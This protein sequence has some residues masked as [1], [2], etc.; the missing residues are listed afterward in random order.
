MLIG[1][2]LNNH[3]FKIGNTWT[4]CLKKQSSHARLY[5][6]ICIYAH[7]QSKVASSHSSLV[8]RFSKILLLYILSEMVG[9]VSSL[10][11]LVIP[12]YLGFWQIFHLLREYSEASVFLNWELTEKEMQET[13]EI[14]VTR[15]KG[16]WG[17]KGMKGKGKSAM[18]FVE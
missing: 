9:A 5:I 15:N 12:L 10:L 4:Q 16:H 7:T 18:I 1:I 14:L 17:K 6:H 11:N 2:I 13:N 8:I 3:L